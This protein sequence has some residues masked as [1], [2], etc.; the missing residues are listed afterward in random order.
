MRRSF[1][2]LGSVAGVTQGV[3]LGLVC[4]ATLGPCAWS[5]RDVVALMSFGIAGATAPTT[6]G[7]STQAP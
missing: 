4:I 5:C 1:R 7:S 3:A 6:Y 2:T